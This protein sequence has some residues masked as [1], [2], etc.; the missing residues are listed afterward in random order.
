VF[1][2]PAGN[3]RLAVGGDYRQE[4]YRDGETFSDTST[5][6]PRMVEAIPLPGPR[7]IR[8]FYAEALVPVFGGEL[9]IPG[10]RRLDFS[11]A[12]R[13]ESYSDFGSTTNPRL[14][15][16]WEPVRGL[17]LRGSY[18]T[19]FR[20]P[21]PDDLRQDPGTTLLFA[22]T[23]PDPASPSGQSN[24]LVQRGNDPDLQPEEATTWSVGAT[25]EPGFLP[26]LRA[27]ASYF[28]I[29][30]RGRI[31]TPA[32]N[33]FNFLVNRETFQ[34]IIEDNPSAETIRAFY[35]SPFFINPLGIPPETITAL[36]DARLQNLSVVRQSGL[37]VDIGYRFTLAG[38]RGEVGAT[39]TY[40]F[41]IDQALTP[42]APARD[43]VDILGNPVDLRIRGRANWS[44]DHWGASMFVN[45][46]DSYTNLTNVTPQ[47]V[48]SWTT[49]D[50]QISYRIPEGRGPLAGMRFA[51]SATNLFD[52]DPPY[53]AYNL[54]VAV[55]SFDADNA[56]PLGRVVSLQ[57]TKAW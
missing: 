17:H 23:I 41:N 45:Y 44:G 47:R 26:G 34:G 37:D 29:D 12:V 50:A 25:V 3:V 40:I 11:A 57:V 16:N 15:L 48:S 4:R 6:E 10:F 2:L 38:G 5:L 8:A 54:G 42:S 49:V 9:V 53:A 52:T 20:A 39:G 56:S 43:V 36:I 51:L 32:A 35:A 33:L 7:R 24:I 28:N 19:S 31:T 18:G 1:S 27:N 55:S 13:T 46:L 21:G 14:G 22:F 30:Y